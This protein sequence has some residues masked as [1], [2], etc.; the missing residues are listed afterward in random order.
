MSLGDH[1]PEQ[2]G[3]AEQ[4]EWD[5]EGGEFTNVTS[6]EPITDWTH[7]FEKFNLDPGR[8]EIISDTVRCSTWQQSK[9]LASGERDVVNLYSYRAQF[10]KRAS[11]HI[12]DDEI[13]ERSER[14]T[15]MTAP[16]KFTRSGGQEVAAVV[17]LADIQGGKREGGGV[18]ATAQRLADG[19]E[20][21]SAWIDR[22]RVH[23]NVS[24]VVLVN[25]GDPVEGCDGNYDTQLF[26]V[27]LN[28]RQQMNFILD[29]WT[30]YARNLFPRFER[31]QFVSVL[32]NHGELGRYGGRK[33]RTDD[34]DNLGGFLAESLRRVLD[35]AGG[36]DHVKW[37]IPEDEMNVYTTAAGVPMAFNHG[38]KIPGNDASGFEKW[39]NGQ[40]R[41]DRSAWDARIWQT[42][43]RHHFQAW[44]LGSCS[45]FQAPS[46]DGGSKWLRDST[47]RFSN[48][49]IICYLVGEH[50]R[51]GWSDLAFL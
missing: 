32:C 48:S 2:P 31:A 4:C 1:L 28:L 33:N 34:A 46:L 36:F 13:R 21:V 18:A 3:P 27:E 26:T 38:H 5:S 37:T 7:V 45:V 8:F 30:A 6:S 11:A 49:G 17:N 50:S 35:G 14:L 23:Y 42:A 51:L 10:R 12:S 16:E 39:L 24:E 40:V 9:R 19:L 47:G 41:G 25:N 29:V 15:T 20:N 22:C 44:D 43:H